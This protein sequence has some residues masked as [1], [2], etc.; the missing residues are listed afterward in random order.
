MVKKILIGVFTS[1]IL[2]S[3][4]LTFANPKHHELPFMV[5]DFAKC[6]EKSKIGVAKNKEMKE[7]NEKLSTQFEEAHKKFKELDT[8]LADNNFLDSISPEEE[9]NL[10]KEK[11]M[12]QQQLGAF[13]MQFQEMLQQAQNKTIHE[14]VQYVNNAAKVIAGEKKSP[15]VINKDTVFYYDPSLDYTNLII[16]QMDKEYETET[17]AVAKDA[18]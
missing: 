17:K 14:L 1:F 9:Q 10:R 8:K 16:D 11:E 3:S 7:L 2:L 15:L 5:A 6:Y 13:Q 18:K 4:T 12:V